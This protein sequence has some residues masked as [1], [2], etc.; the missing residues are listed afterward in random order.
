[1]YIYHNPHDLSSGHNLGCLVDVSEA[2]I[3]R[4]SHY[5]ACELY[6]RKY[7][8]AYS[9]IHNITLLLHNVLVTSYLSLQS[10]LIYI[11]TVFQ[12]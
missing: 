8:I 2:H 7:C 9:S 12:M 11:T 5:Y 3:T 1:M 6:L 10:N 4:S